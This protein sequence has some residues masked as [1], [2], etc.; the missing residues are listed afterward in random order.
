[1]LSKNILAR[2]ELIMAALTA[3][4]RKFYEENGYLLYRRQLFPPEKLQA[5]QKIFEEHLAGKGDKLSDELDTPH[6]RDERLL[7][8]LLSEEALDL[9]EPLIGPNIGLWSSHFICKDPMVGRA[10]PWHE[11]SAYWKGRLSGYDKIVTIWL[12]LDRSTRENGC[13]RVIPGTHRNGFS[14][15]EPVD[16]KRNLFRSQIRNL[17][18]SGAVYFELEP[19]ECSLH[20]SRIIHGAEPNTSPYRRCGYTMRYFSTELKLL[21]ERNRNF[22]VWLAR[23]KDLAGNPFVN[24]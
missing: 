24:V 1:M 12:A 3:E 11:D 23:G 17:D 18:D 22:K 10:T 6:F 5:L 8:F 20:D 4:D 2:E 13:M 7:E 15:Y 16:G 14:E 19:G 9:V 21:P